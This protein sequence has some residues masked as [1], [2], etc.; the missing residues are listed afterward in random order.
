MKRIARPRSGAPAPKPEAT[1]TKNATVAK[2]RRHLCGADRRCASK[3]LM[4]PLHFHDSLQK[5][6]TRVAC[7]HNIAGCRAGTAAV[8]RH[9]RCVAGSG[10]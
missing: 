6:E 9:A 5:S 10:P 4:L 3:R 7:A 8:N 1:I 2:G